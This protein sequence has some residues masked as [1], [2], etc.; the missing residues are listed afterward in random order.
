VQVSD[1]FKI[2][3]VFHFYLSCLILPTNEMGHCP[4]FKKGI[5][6][7]PDGDSHQNR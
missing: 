2:V 4:A 1:D 5:H 3:C 7:D 6:L